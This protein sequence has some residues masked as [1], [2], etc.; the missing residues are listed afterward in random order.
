MSMVYSDYFSIIDYY[1]KVVIPFNPKKYRVKSDKMMVCPLHDDINPS[2]GII[3]GKDGEELYHC[4]GC[5]QW[6]NIV[7]FNKKVNRRL[8]KK[9]L[10]DEDSLRDLCRLF[11][12]PFDEVSINENKNIDEGVQFE[13]AI[14]SAKDRFDIS[15]LR[16][17]FI[18]G[19]LSKRGVG[20]YNALLMMMINELKKESDNID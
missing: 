20:Y 14:Q 13:M 10:S 6:G 4:F 2:L 19:K 7:E 12:V 11:N 3:K 9:N 16:E 18:E 8:Y 15:D 17:K 5:N 1:K